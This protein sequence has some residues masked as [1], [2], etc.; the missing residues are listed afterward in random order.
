MKTAILIYGVF[1]IAG[2][3]EE[4]S[5]AYTGNNDGLLAGKNITSSSR[6][7]PAVEGCRTAEKFEFLK[8]RAE[9]NRKPENNGSIG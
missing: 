6:D 7:N 4:T 1:N 2:A 9:P 8:V 3:K 5:R